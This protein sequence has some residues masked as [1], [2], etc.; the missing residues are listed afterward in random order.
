MPQVLSDPVGNSLRR[1][2]AGGQFSCPEKFNDTLFLNNL[3]MPGRIAFSHAL[4]RHPL[5]GKGPFDIGNGNLF[6]PFKIPVDLIDKVMDVLFGNLLAVRVSGRRDIG[7]P[8]KARVFKGNGAPPAKKAGS[9]NDLSAAG[10][11]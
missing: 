3:D 10:K 8:D 6:T 9:P 5:A 7:C 2:P 4:E 11:Q 1:Q